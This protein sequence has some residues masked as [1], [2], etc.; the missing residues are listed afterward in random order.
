MFVVAISP[1]RV[2]NHKCVIYG[3]SMVVDPNGEIKAKAGIAEEILF[4]EIG[5]SLKNYSFSICY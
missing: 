3:H 4:Y 2:E 5:S 1:A